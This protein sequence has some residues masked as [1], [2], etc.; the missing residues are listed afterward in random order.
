MRADVAGVPAVRRGAVWVLRVVGVYLLR[1]VVLVLLQALLAFETGP[2]LGSHSDPVAFPDA[3]NL[4]SDFD[5]S[6]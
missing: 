2:N 3:F 1:A 4:L 6:V 5:G